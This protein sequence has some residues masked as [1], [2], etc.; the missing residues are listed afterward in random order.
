MKSK[1]PEILDDDTKLGRLKAQ[2]E[3]DEEAWKIYQV[4]ET[5]SKKGDAAAR[6]AALLEAELALRAT[7]RAEA[8][9]EEVGP[10]PEEFSKDQFQRM[11]NR[12]LW[13]SAIRQII[14]QLGLKEH[15]ETI[16]EAFIAEDFGLSASEGKAASRK[17]MY[18]GGDNGYFKYL[19]TE[20]M[21]AKAGA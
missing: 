4:L 8:E 16:I 7:R 14:E 3:K 17:M 10:I 5:L 1:T 6:A 9:G 18:F 21:K 2:I 12:V 20:K 15:E 19:L 13:F 11:Y